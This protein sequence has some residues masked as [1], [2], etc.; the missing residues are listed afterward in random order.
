MRDRDHI[1]LSLWRTLSSRTLFKNWFIQIIEEK[2]EHPRLGSM[3]YY[4]AETPTDSVAV[5]ALTEE[6]NILL[7]R[8]YR[9]PLGHIIFDLPA[10]RLESGED[11]AIGA[12][13]ELEEETGYTA[14]R[15][16]RLG[17]MVPYPGSLRIAIHLYLAQGLKRLPKGQHTDP[18]EE[19][20]VVTLP[21]HQVLAEI[22]EGRYVD[23]SL[24]YG[25]LMAAQ[26]LGIVV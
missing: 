1:Q 9:H 8:Q 21:F 7:T 2:I 6:E 15:V 25:V 4:I 24:Q 12:R 11:P 22:V 10:G 19:V 14:N 5:V 26:K 13:R 3:S 23:G 20:Q 18:K 16:E 17:Y